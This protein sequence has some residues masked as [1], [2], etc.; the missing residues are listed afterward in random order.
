MGGGV[1]GVVLAIVFTAII[2]YLVWYNIL[3][4][5]TLNSSGTL[6]ASDVTNINTSKTILS[7]FVVALAAVGLLAIFGGRA[8]R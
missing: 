1:A 2:V 4:T 7:I 3:N 6:T 8:G 5:S